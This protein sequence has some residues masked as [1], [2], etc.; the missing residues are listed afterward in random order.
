M[1][2]FTLFHV[3]ATTGHHHWRFWYL[4]R[5][6]LHPHSL[7]MPLATRI[8]KVLTS[9]YKVPSLRFTHFVLKITSAF[10]GFWQV[11][12][13][14]Y[15]PLLIEGYVAYIK[16][17]R[18]DTVPCLCSTLFVLKITSAFCICWTHWSAFQ[19]IF[20]ETNAMN[21]DQTAPR[22]TVWSRSIL[23]QNLVCWG[24]YVFGVSYIYLLS[25]TSHT[26]CIVARCLINVVY[27]TACY[28]YQVMMTLHF[29]NDVA[30]DAE[31][32]Q[33][34]KNTSLSLVRRV[35]NNG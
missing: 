10:W 9:W 12:F 26:N 27:L 23:Y 24:M 13:S 30:N 20:T 2:I 7:N 21:N 29:L 16:F 5:R 22:E 4:V 25:V 19:I 28:L 35:F 3:R 17:W 1:I 15:V 14:D 31:S 6:A 32:T 33:K 18:H 8:H 34:S 11:F